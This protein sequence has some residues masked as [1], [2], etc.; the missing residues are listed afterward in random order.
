MS[1]TIISAVRKFVATCPHLSEFAPVHV[2][3]TAEEATNYGVASSGESPVQ[4]YFTGD[5][6][7]RHN[8]ALY[9]REY[10]TND[11][12]RLTNSGFLERFANWL[13]E[14]TLTSGLPDLGEGRKA[15]EMGSANAMLFDLNEDG[16]TGLYQIQFYLLYEQ[17]RGYENGLSEEL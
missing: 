17:E 9:A 7:R 16:Q 13:E 4:R 11:A 5:T 1:N 10:T 12:E 8:F 2:D 15:E 3:F 14:Q 6:L